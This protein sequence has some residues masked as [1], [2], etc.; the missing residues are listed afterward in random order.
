MEAAPRSRAL[1]QSGER[2]SVDAPM[3]IAGSCTVGREAEE[4]DSVP[5]S[6][7]CFSYVTS[8]RKPSLMLLSFD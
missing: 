1:G 5:S 4:T 8:S 6:R 7:G 2:D 3:A